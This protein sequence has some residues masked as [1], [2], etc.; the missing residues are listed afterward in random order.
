[1]LTQTRVLRAHYRET[2]KLQAGISKKGKDKR[3]KEGRRRSERGGTRLPRAPR[4][5]D[6]PKIE[7]FLKK[8]EFLNNTRGTVI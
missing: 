1:M 2:P 4:S 6:I 5:K 8:T 7:N 3:M